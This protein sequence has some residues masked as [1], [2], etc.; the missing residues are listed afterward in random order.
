MEFFNHMPMENIKKE[1]EKLREQIRHHNEM[2]YVLDSPEISDAEYDR[3]FH[4][5]LEIEKAHPELVTPDSPTQQ[6][7]GTPQKTFAQ[8]RHSIPMLS[9]DNVFDENGIRDFDARVRKLLPE[10]PVIEYTVEPKMDGLAIE[11]VYEKGHLVVASTRG[12]GYVGEDVTRNIKTI[13]SIPL[14]LQ[15]HD[16]DL[17]IPDLLEVR[18]EVYMEKHAFESLNRE[19]LLKNMPP[20][21]NP[22]NAA[23]GSLRQLNPK[24]TAKRHLDMFCYGVG[25]VIPMV[26]ET[27][28]E[29]MLD[30]QALGLRVNR[31]YINLCTSVH[32]IISYCHHLEDI[33]LDLPYEID[34][35]VIKV[36]RL[37]LQARLGHKTR[38]PRWAVAYKFKPIQEVTRILKIDVQVGR[39]GALTPVAHLEPVEVDGVIVKRA[40]LHNQEEIARKDIREGDVVI[41]QRAGDVIPEIVQV[42]KSRRTGAEK[43]FVMPDRCPVCNSL[44]EKDGVEKVVRCPN[45]DCPAQIKETLKHFVSK[46]AMDIKGLGEKTIT[47]LIRNGLISEKADI[48]RLDR[49]TLMKLD[50]VDVKMADNL[51]RSIDRSKKTTLARFIYAIGI[52]H[53]GEYVA[54]LLAKEYRTWEAFQ[55]AV[56]ELRLTLFVVELINGIDCIN[57]LSDDDVLSEFFISKDNLLDILSD[58]CCGLLRFIGF[59]S[60]IRWPKR[61]L[62]TIKGLGEKIAVSLLNFFDDDSNLE[63][64]RHLFD[65]GITFEEMEEEKTDLDTSV[66][67]KT[68]VFTG[69]LDSMTRSEAKAL[70]E[71]KGGRVSSQVT[72]STDYLVVGK[73]PGSKLERAK[74]R[75][76]TVIDETAFLN[77]IESTRMD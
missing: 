48:Y 39:T 18:G 77:L 30:L 54:D 40:T 2:Y 68:F 41:V 8:V 34:G 1:A 16:K 58:C 22:R 53:V 59:I 52:R 20:F 65:A 14:V 51:L 62:M 67:G 69:S 33:R 74:E 75:G 26:Y 6:V 49:D 38:S 11:I 31:P 25:R 42:V 44:V 19:R 61:P 5:L 28:Y 15:R 76:V 50:K 64:I 56:W 47:N 73:S 3:L 71:K 70:I 57:R 66:A 32:E 29:L 36:N 21:A 9:L 37:D 55:E 12:D 10:H 35:A 24:V 63:E 45:P 43:K 4:R 13:I 46:G 60:V 7:G 72:S 27:Q 23:A 17:P